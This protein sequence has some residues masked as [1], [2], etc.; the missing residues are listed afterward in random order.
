[1]RYI[2]HLCNV[3]LYVRNKVVKNAEPRHTEAPI[4][5]LLMELGVL[6]PMQ[7]AS[8]ADNYVEEY[9]TWY[10]EY[11]QDPILPEQRL[12]KVEDKQSWFS[13]LFKRKKK[14]K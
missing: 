11:C 13:S 6:P 5:Y 12:F 3:G 14:K 1:M 4:L 10:D 7:R 2:F 9:E 8:F